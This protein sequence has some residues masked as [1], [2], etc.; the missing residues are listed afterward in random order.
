MSHSQNNF[1][2]RIPEDW[3]L[4]R[5]K[6]VKVGVCDTGCDLS[7]KALQKTNIEHESFGGGANKSHGTQIA[8]IIVGNPDDIYTFQSM[9]PLSNM[10][11]ADIQTKG[12][13]AYKS[14]RQALEWII[15]SK[16]DVLNL[17]FAYPNDNEEIKKLLID[18]SK[19][20]LI[21][22]AYSPILEF[23]HSY[24]E[25]ISVGMSDEPVNIITDGE[26]FSTGLNNKY[27]KVRGT[28]FS[29]ALMSSV[30]CL[31]KSYDKEID[32]E[33]FLLTVKG[34]KKMEKIKDRNIISS[35]LKQVNLSFD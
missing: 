28:S 22:C 13:L 31:A 26:C 35:P 33:K 17:S 12:D 4:T 2:S 1:L 24:D 32:K 14:F 23:P 5:G 21:F 25:V 8:G 11:F 20:T 34:N 29:T 6:N 10:F 27:S 18:I 19:N 16:V 3:L 30:G 9:S 7:H 15:E